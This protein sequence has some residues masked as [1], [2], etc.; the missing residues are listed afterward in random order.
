M[1]LMT[2]IQRLVTLLHLTFLFLRSGKSPELSDEGASSLGAQP[3]ASPGA[4]A[5]EGV[6]SG[7]VRLDFGDVA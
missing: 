3:Q 5:R 6:R 1:S 2:Q 7:A 4:R